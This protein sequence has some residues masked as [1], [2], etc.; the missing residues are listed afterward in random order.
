MITAIDT[1]V[2]LDVF[3]ADERF[4][5]RS[6]QALRRSLLEGGVVACEAVWAEIAGFFPTLD[7]VQRGM[8]ELAVDFSPMSQAAA[9]A[10]GAAWKEYRRRGGRRER[11]IADFLTGAHAATQADRLLTR[12]RGFY[13]R[14]FAKL[15][16]LEPIAG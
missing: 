9:L 6:A 1:S 12:D 4:G 10:A 3:A 14:Y 11:V 16:L 7:A 5:S 15:R 8:G 13:R 2:L